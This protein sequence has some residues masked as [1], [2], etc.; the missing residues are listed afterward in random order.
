V[1]RIESGS[2]STARTFST[3]DSI[4]AKVDSPEPQPTSKKVAFSNAAGEIKSVSP[5]W[6]WLC[7]CHL[8]SPG[9]KTN[10]FRKQS[11]DRH[12]LSLSKVNDSFLFAKGTLL[13]KLLVVLE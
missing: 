10:S 3:P 7:C 4:A 8:R 9:M 5:P 13:H 6:P 1:A 11:V 12:F 2:M